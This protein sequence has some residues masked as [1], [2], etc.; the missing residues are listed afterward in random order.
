MIVAMIMLHI[1]YVSL[2]KGAMDPV[3]PPITQF[4]ES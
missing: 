4:K 2:T 1:C 3:T